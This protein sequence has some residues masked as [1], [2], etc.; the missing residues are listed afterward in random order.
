[1]EFYLEGAFIWI[2]GY[3]YIII[4]FCIYGRYEE[5]K[6]EGGYFN[7]VYCDILEVFNVSFS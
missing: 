7:I 2:L 1:M 6:R 3:G 5:R 4:F